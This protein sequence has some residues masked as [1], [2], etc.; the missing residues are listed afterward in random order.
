VK[1][2]QRRR[3]LHGFVLPSGV[4]PGWYCATHHADRL[5]DHQ[6]GLA[7][8]VP[9]SWR[10]AAGLRERWSATNGTTCARGFR[11]EVFMANDLKPVARPSREMPWTYGLA[12]TRIAAY[13]PSRH[14]P[15]KMSQRRGTVE[16]MKGTASAS[17]RGVGPRPCRPR[18]REENR[19][20]KIS[21]TRESRSREKELDSNPTVCT[22][23]DSGVPALSVGTVFELVNYVDVPIPCLMA[24][25]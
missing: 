3:G 1:G 11:V 24:H 4:A 16:P 12:R 6:P 14:R 8:V 22:V 21:E 23:P 5:G 19:A 18:F 25:K 20:F 15:E 17:D 13:M 2:S 10:I 9:A 7:G